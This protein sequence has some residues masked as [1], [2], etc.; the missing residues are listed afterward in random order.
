M[1]WVFACYAS[2][3]VLTGAPFCVLASLSSSLCE[4]RMEMMR[5]DMPVPMVMCAVVFVWLCVPETKGKSLSDIQTE[6]A[7]VSCRSPPPPTPRHIASI[8]MNPYVWRVFKARIFFILKNEDCLPCASGG[9]SC[10]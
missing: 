8:R 9:E 4:V 6:L 10:A 2:V 5:R 7:T 3:A 1:G